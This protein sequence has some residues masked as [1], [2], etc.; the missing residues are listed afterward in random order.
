MPGPSEAYKCV[1]VLAL[2]LGLSA[3][4]SGPGED[5]KGH[6][7]AVPDRLLDLRA[8]I[9]HLDA[10][11]IRLLAERF[12]VTREVGRLKSE[13]A[14]PASDREREARQIARLRTLASEAGPDP[15]LAERLHA[16]VVAEVKRNHEVVAASRAAV[17]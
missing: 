9:D 5:A 8:S 6:G 14:L 4:A 7:G 3:C 15:D 2:S 16:F 1:A 11:V 17:R 12:R 13:L 10:A